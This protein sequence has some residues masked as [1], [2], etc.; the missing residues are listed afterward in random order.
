MPMSRSSISSPDE[1]LVIRTENLCNHPE[2]F[3]LDLGVITC[4]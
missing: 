4:K 1:F 2:V 3:A